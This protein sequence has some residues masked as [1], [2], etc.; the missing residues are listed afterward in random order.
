MTVWDT[1]A[2]TEPLGEMEG[3][4][5]GVLEVEEVAVTVWDTEPLGEMVGVA[6]GV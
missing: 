1:E 5:E 6:E 3:V 2:V 4:A